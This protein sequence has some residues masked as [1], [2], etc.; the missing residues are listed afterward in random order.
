MGSKKLAGRHWV[1]EQIGS[2]R[3]NQRKRQALR[4]R[5]LRFEQFE[6]RTLLSVAPT[7]IDD[8]LVNQTGALSPNALSGRAV[9]GDNNGDFV[10]TWSQ[11]DTNGAGGQDTNIYARYYTNAVQRID[12]PT[13]TQS[14]ALRY[15]GNAIEKLSVSAETQPYTDVYDNGVN[16]VWG[17]FYLTYTDPVSGQSYTGT[18]NNFDELA[19][20]P[21]FNAASIKQALDDMASLGA[22]ALVGA[23]VQGIDASDYQINFGPA[24]GGNWQPLL[25]ATYDDGSGANTLQG[26]LPAVEVSMVRQPNT[27]TIIPVSSTNA[28]L[29]VQ[30]IENAFSQISP[31]F[32]IA[33]TVFSQTFLATYGTPATLTTAIPSVSVT[34]R[35]TTEFDITFT[36]NGTVDSLDG[37]QESSVSFTGGGDMADQPLMQLT[38][39]DAGGNVL[40]PDGGGVRILKQSSDVFRVNDPEWQDPQ[41]LGSQYYDQTNPQV[42]MNLDGSFVITWE[43]VVPD[44]VNYG[45]V[46][47]IYARRFSPAGW[48]EDAYRDIVFTPT[49]AFGLSSGQFELVTAGGSVPITFFGTSDADLAMTAAQIENALHTNFGFDPATTVSVMSDNAPYVL[50]VNWGGSD[51]GQEPLLECAPIIDPVTLQPDLNADIATQSASSAASPIVLYRDIRFDPT[52]ASTLTGQFQLTTGYG[53]TAA[54]G[55]LVNGNVLPTDVTLDVASAAGFPLATATDPTSW[56]EIKVDDEVMLVTNESGVGGTTWTVTRAQDGTAAALHGVNAGVQLYIN[57]D[58]SNLAQTAIDVQN[59]LHALGYDPA[60]TVTVENTSAPY[61]LRVNWGGADLGQDPLLEYNAVIDP[62]TYLPEV[63]ANVTISTAVPFVAD[64]NDDGIADTPIEGVRALDNQFQV[65]TLTTNAQSQASIGMDTPGTLPS[66]GRAK[67]RT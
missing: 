51:L 35:S 22:T 56:F 23:T 15:N 21:S 7:T 43:G 4:H 24:S 42:A 10:V 9:A 18:V 54:I 31:T 12:L 58:Y 16:D 61:V 40:N 6:E 39:M 8:V 41:S 49:D 28:S 14:I 63:A 53:T 20:S 36:G 46:S 44:S 66:Y 1:A 27:T 2:R 52:G 60:T 65:N 38:A 64:M 32:D 48:A 25:V 37:A 11:T 50:R 3:G 67:G 34:A 19:G 57:F 17:F 26:F 47:D 33:P 62:A 5:G 55:T 13:G 30:N 45:S 59:A 29:T